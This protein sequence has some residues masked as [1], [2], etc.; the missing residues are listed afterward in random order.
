VVEEVSGGSARRERDEA[1]QER[2]VDSGGPGRAGAA[3]A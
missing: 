2:Q 3:G 1:A